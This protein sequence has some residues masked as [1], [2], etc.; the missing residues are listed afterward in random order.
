MTRHILFAAAAM[1][2]AAIGISPG[3]AQ[4]NTGQIT[5]LYDA[6]GK[7]AAMRKDWGFSALVEVAGKRILFP[8]RHPVPPAF[9]R[10]LHHLGI[11]LD[12]GQPGRDQR[13]RRAAGC[14]LG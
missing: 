4:S 13:R 8:G 9:Q 14:R 7:D 2:V 12:T 5:I 1:I 11:D 3:F 10:R 6:F